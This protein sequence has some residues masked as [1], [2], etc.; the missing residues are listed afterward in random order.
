MDFI[1]LKG[2]IM[3]SF[4]RSIPELMNTLERET[5]RM[6]FMA[7]VS[8]FQHSLVHP[9]VVAG[10]ASCSLLVRAAMAMDEVLNCDP[11]ASCGRNHDELMGRPTATLLD[12]YFDPE[13]GHQ[14]WIVDDPNNV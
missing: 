11:Y 4:D 10:C 5:E 14:V 2:S 13:T 12:M 8:A 9:E 6:A 3:S 1:H 7:R